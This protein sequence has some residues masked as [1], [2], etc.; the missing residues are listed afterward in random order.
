[1]LC[2]M[3]VRQS[4]QKHLCSFV[5]PFDSFFLSYTH[6]ICFGVLLF[7][8]SVATIKSSAELRCKQLRG[9]LA[10]TS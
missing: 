9:E 1:M 7:F 2:L 8:L 10:K 3:C 5:L 6:T 4:D